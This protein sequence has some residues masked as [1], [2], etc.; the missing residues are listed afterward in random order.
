MINL[1]R[2]VT[3]LARSRNALSNMPKLGAS[4]PMDPITPMEQPPEITGNA[5]APNAV[6]DDEQEAAIEFIEL[7]K[8]RNG[9]MNWQACWI[10][11][12]KKGCRDLPT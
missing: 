6:T 11:S 12:Q 5:Q 3:A 2:Y 10:K 7:F 1:Q 4:T 8:S 9:R